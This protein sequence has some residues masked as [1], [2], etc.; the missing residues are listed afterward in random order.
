M[1]LIEE[2]GLLKMDFLGLCNLDV[3]EDMIVIIE[4]LIGECVDMVMFLL[5]DFKIY[6]MMVVGDLVGVF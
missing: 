2:I 6:E 1:K 3:I 4:C 5:D